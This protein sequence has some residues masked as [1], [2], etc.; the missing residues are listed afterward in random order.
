M[1]HFTHDM[2]VGAIWL[3]DGIPGVAKKFGISEN[4]V[5]KMRRGEDIRDASQAKVNA[6]WKKM[7]SEQKHA[8]RRGYELVDSLSPKQ[9]RFLSER[10]Y[11]GRKFSRAARQYTRRKDAVPKSVGRFIE[12]AYAEEEDEE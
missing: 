11:S 5:R 12:E 10:G 6:A 8:I 3:F 9:Q 1:P 4:E 2:T 7:T